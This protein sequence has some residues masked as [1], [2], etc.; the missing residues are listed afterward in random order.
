MK[1]FCKNEHSEVHHRQAKKLVGE[2]DPKSTVDHLS[3]LT[4]ENKGGTPGIRM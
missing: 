3:K 4:S 2:Y 1:F